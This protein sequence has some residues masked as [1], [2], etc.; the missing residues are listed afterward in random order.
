MQ[1][2]RRRSRY[3]PC[4]KTGAYWARA[5]VAPMRFTS[6]RKE[7]RKTAPYGSPTWPSGL[8]VV[9]NVFLFFLI[10]S[11]YRCNRPSSMPY[12]CL[13]VSVSIVDHVRVSRLSCS[14]NRLVIHRLRYQ[15][16]RRGQHP[17][18]N[19]VFPS[20]FVEHAGQVRRRDDD[21]RAFHEHP[22]GVD[23]ATRNRGA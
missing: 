3:V 7:K 13:S 10:D 9:P 1:T 16:T 15:I 14:S 12:L 6:L 17:K 5:L 4:R 18:R 8:A 23:V 21:S 2:C 19:V 22:S 20:S 11:F